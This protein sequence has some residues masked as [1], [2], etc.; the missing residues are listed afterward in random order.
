MFVKEFQDHLSQFNTSPFLFVGSG[1]SRRYYDLPDWESLL[2]LLVQDLDLPKPF[3]Y[4]FSNSNSE[5]P[6]T[7]SKI[8]KDFKEDWWSKERFE[9]SRNLFKDKAISEYCPLKYEVCNFIDSKKEFLGGEIIESELKLLKKV[10]IDGIITTNWDN[11]CEKLFPTFNSYIGQQE[12]LFTELF[13]IGEIYKIHGCISNPSSIVLTEEDYADFNDRN[14]YLAAKLLTIFVENPIVFIGYSLDD[15]NVQDLLKTIIKCLNKEKLEHLKNR[16][17]FCKWSRTPIE[18]SIVD[19][20]MTIS[21]TVLPIKLITAHSFEEIYTVLANN[22]KKIPTKILRQMKGMIYDFVKN[23]NSKQKIYV[24]DNLDSIED[25]KNAEFVYGVGIKD[26]LSEQGIKGLE[27]RDLLEEAIKSK[28][29]SSELICLTYLPSIETRARFIPFFKH[30]RKGGYLNS[31]GEI[32]SETEITEFTPRFINKINSI[33]IE[34]FYPAPSYIKKKEE[35]NNF[36][37]SIEDIKK[38][39]SNILHQMLYIPLLN[40]NNI[41]IVDL[42]AF[43]EENI[44]LLDDSKHGSH[45]RKLVCLFD[46]LKHKY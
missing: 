10:N 1:F 8:G 43:L 22:K 2:K 45:F 30:L 3:E 6:L 4:Y 15:K 38:K 11:L 40:K 42:H 34:D 19:S 27:L 24:T 41:N 13:N 5:L 23:N 26:K 16:L 33:T 36:C 31:I 18:T 9:N 21:E 39:Y 14:T 32:D 37:K 17:I 29:W 25:F 20:Y 7:A 44:K 35:I 28:N 12:L 46:Y